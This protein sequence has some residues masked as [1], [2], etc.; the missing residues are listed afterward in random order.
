MQALLSGVDFGPAT[1]LVGEN[2][3]GKS[4]LVEGVARAWG[5]PAEGGSTWEQ[6]QGVEAPS[7]L[8]EHLQL[9]RG[10][11]APRTGFFLRAETMHGFSAYLTEVGSDRGYRLLRRSHGQF[12]LDLL[13]GAA[14]SPG[15]WILDEPEAGLSFQGQLALLGLLAERT[16]AGSQVLVSTHSPLLARLPEAAILEVG[17]WGLRRSR[18]EDLELV[19]HWRA[20][21]EEPRRYLR[22]L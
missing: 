9:T 21:L 3:V 19:E 16:A 20:F 14:A 1:V 2:G 15:L 4:T 12:I 8:A 5:F 22:H 17:D 13:M 18:W 11:G 10:G 6:R 7:L